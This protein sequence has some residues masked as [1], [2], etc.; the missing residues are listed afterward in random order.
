MPPYAWSKQTIKNSLCKRDSSVVWES[1]IYSGRKNCLFRP[2]SAWRGAV[3]EY[4]LYEC[5]RLFYS[6]TRLLQGKEAILCFWRTSCCRWYQIYSSAVFSKQIG[7]NRSNHFQTDQIIPTSTN[8]AT[9]RLSDLFSWM[10][11]ETARESKFSR[12]HLHQTGLCFQR[13]IKLSGTPSDCSSR[14]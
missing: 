4:S 10:E 12:N 9:A 14:L 8:L 13:T 6:P 1:S 3:K 7:N 2:W 5:C 11:A